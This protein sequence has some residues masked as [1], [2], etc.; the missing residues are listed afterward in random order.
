MTHQIESIS[1]VEV[2]LK[3]SKR[4]FWQAHIEEWS[5]SRLKQAEYC[6]LHQLSYRKFSYW[7]SKL[8][9]HEADQ[10]E[11][12]QLPVSTSFGENEFSGQDQIFIGHETSEPLKLSLNSKY[13]I[14][15]PEGFSE[16]ALKKV[17]MTLGVL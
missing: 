15:I 9:N 14:E 5:Q 6:R 17:L 2:E 7:K 16:I 10:V 1:E 13:A 12:A 4:E 3:V 11:F 8:F